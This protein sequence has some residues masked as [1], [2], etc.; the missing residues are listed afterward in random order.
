[1]GYPKKRLGR[2]GKTV[3]YTA[4]YL[5]LR[6]VLRSAGTYSSE[7]EANKAWQAAEAKL[8]EGRAGDPARQRRRF[9]RYVEAEWLPHHVMEPTTRESYTYMIRKHILPRFGPMK[10]IEI[11]PS[12]VREWITELRHGGV[13]PATIESSGSSLARSS[14]RRSTTRSRSCTL[15]AASRHRLFRRSR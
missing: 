2:D 12:H 5:D 1:M 11:L 9:R 15:A 6:G 3:R 13:G 14:P 10:M 4:C 8:A 7:K